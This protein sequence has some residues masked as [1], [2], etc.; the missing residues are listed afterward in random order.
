MLIVETKLIQC[1]V[2]DMNECG[3]NNGGCEGSC[4]DTDGGYECTCAEGF[5]LNANNHTCDGTL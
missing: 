5:E 2:S 4:K 1:G 3:T